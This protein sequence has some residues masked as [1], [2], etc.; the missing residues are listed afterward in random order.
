MI[1]LKSTVVVLSLLASQ[2]TAVPTFDAASPASNEARGL[3][4]DATNAIQRVWEGIKCLGDCRK[5]WGWTGNHFGGDPWGPPLKIGDPVP[6]TPSED[7]SGIV[8]TTTTARSTTR[9]SSA[10]GG[11]GILNVDTS[12]TT[13][14]DGSNVEFSVFNVPTLTRSTSTSTIVLPTSTTPPPPPPEP[15][16]TFQE[17]QPS[18]EPQ[19]SSSQ[20]QPQPQE[21]PAPSP[22]PS[23]NDNNN[24]NNV[25]NNNSGGSTQGAAGDIAAYLAAHN[26]ARSQ[27]GASP[28]SWSDELAGFAQEWA[29]NCQFQHSQ[30]KFGRVGENLAAGTGQYSIEDMV[31]DWVAEVTDY[32][33]S[34]P[35]ASHFTQVVWKA[36]TQIGCAKQTCTGI[37]G[38]TPATY[39]VCEYREAGNVIGNFAANVQA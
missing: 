13:L 7:S 11:F 6:Y 22:T 4:D 3:V 5:S 38:N 8:S 17:P 32:N 29:N 19:P 10:E 31:G 26:S 34:N 1:A 28:V 39:Y 36:T 25:G 12:R 2:A 18:P 33:P 9:T 15:T 20:E 23:N 27:H 35:K 14:V 24:N 37:F 30:G 16:T 21:Q